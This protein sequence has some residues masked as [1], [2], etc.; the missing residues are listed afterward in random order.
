[1]PPSLVHPRFTL[2]V[3]LLASFLDLRGAIEVSRVGDGG[4]DTCAVLSASLDAAIGELASNVGS[5][6]AIVALG[7]YGRREQCLWSDIDIM[8]LHD[9]TD[10]EP[11][12]RAVLY[13]L[14]DAHLKVGH[15]VRTVA[16]S[17]QAGNESFETLTSLLSGRLIA[18]DS[19]LFER[20]MV[21]VTDLVRGNPLTLRLIAQERERRATDPFPVMAA[22]LKEGRGALRTHQGFW[23][24]RRRAAILGLPVDE[25]QPEEVEARAVLLSVRNA[26]HAAAGRQVDRF[27]LDLR[28]HAARWLGTDVRT[29]AEMLTAA[30]AEGDRLA[31]R[32][33]SGL[34]AETDP[35][36]KFGRRI[37]RA[38]QGRLS[39]VDRREDDGDSVL[40]LAVRAAGR[41]DGAWF[42][43]AEESRIRDAPD[44]EWTASDRTAFVMLLSA[45]AR[46][47]TILGRLE[48]LGWLAKE[49]P[50]WGPVATAPQLAPFHDHP[51]GA[52]LLRTVSE[53]L[54]L[55]E[56]GGE[57][58]AIA[59]EVGSS[60]ELLLTAFLHDIGK[61]RGGD[62]AH[63]GAE[64]AT[65]FLRRVGFGPAT[66]ESVTQSVRLHLLLSETATRRDIASLEVIDEV[67]TVVGDRRQLQILYLLTIA[68]LRATGTTMWNTWRASLLGTLYRRVL[69]AIEI[70]SAPPATPDV[71][72]VL[73]ADVGS[74]DRHVLEEHIA[75]MPPSY[76]ETTS[77]REVL[78]HM[79]AAEGLDGSARLCPDP[80]D[81]GHVLAV[82]DDRSGFLLAVSRAF[83]A[84]GI[85]VL[86]ARVRTRSDGIALDTFHVCDDRTGEPIARDRWNR[87]AR[88]LV[89]SLAGDRDLRPVIRQRVLA[90]HRPDRES[91][92]VKVRTATA[93]RYLRIDVRIPDG[94]GVFTTIVKALYGEGLDIH[95]AR[96]DTMGGE[97]RD[98]FYVRR[99][100][101]AGI[102]S[103]S[104][105]TALRRRLADRLKG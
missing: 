19:D 36:I 14:W 30:L 81:P 77:P 25:P 52:H 16:E 88:D 31:D 64:L 47:H 102:V 23:W 68:D 79:K 73:V 40:L 5:G 58:G 84:N 82:G 35:M 4:L 44:T 75:A 100:G 67:A 28:E 37:F 91:T 13:P 105:M 6:I 101:D 95:L 49:F 78:W 42:T 12:V 69:E 63:V 29:L 97:T 43:D 54:A 80:D 24:E 9:G 76:L 3:S 48:A 17:S 26:L 104:E 34:H 71:E 59:D 62:H 72:A 45:G 22:N 86:D 96:I 56:G 83:A 61:A 90:Y 98:V 2:I 87:V 32:R 85:A 38:L 74:V 1:M 10:P 60:E 70:G 7:G 21:T 8:V 92:R 41:I 51:V 50:E 65:R 93:G 55:I 46:G 20:L 18:G 11:A 99:V 39:A 33:W 66:V 103:D 27:A 89:D 53:M 57:H 15:A 94:V